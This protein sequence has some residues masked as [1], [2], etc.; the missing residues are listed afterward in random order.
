[1]RNKGKYKNVLRPLVE[2]SRSNPFVT[3]VKG[4]SKKIQESPDLFPAI[5]YP[6]SQPSISNFQLTSS[7]PTNDLSRARKRLRG[8]PVSPS[9]NK[10]KRRRVVV[11]S[12]LPFTD[13]LP[14]TGEE[15][16]L[17]AAEAN[18]SFVDDSPVKAPA[19]GKA[20]K[21]LFE[22]AVDK[23]T[24][25]KR[26]LSRTMSVSTGLFGEPSD[27]ISVFGNGDQTYAITSIAKEKR[28]VTN[29]KVGIPSGRLPFND[30][31][32]VNVPRQDVFPGPSSE[33]RTSTK[34]LLPDIE[35]ERR[36]FDMS[37]QPLLPPSP[38]SAEA[39]THGSTKHKGKEKANR[40]S[41][42][43]VKVVKGADDKDDDSEEGS[44]VKV[45]IHSRESQSRRAEDDQDLDL[46]L[47][48]VLRFRAHRGPRGMPAPID[49]QDD[50]SR[51][52]VDLPDRIRNVL[53]IS[54]SKPRVSREERVVRGILHGGRISHYDPSKG[55]EIWD[56]GELDYESA[57]ANTEGEDDW[58]REPV[59]WEVGEL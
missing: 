24:N 49:E 42:K 10:Q 56:V 9:P 2:D 22:E 38:P 37:L 54:P 4:K 25:R 15:D 43:K 47:G 50:M 35:L 11:P 27:Q 5:Q 51:F 41:R 34:H 3:P 21:L 33:A 17:D 20:F 44:N 55:G 40:V 36:E 48:P 29:G 45:V 58:D 53:A 31:G 28:K 32:G 12:S 26:A 23:P 18:S 30:S 8:E 19:G 13:Q 1:V 16:D 6:Q 14:N 52:E 57:G 59:P 39:G 46:D 7:A